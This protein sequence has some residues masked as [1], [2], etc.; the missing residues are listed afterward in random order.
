MSAAQ[1][2]LAGLKGQKGGD[3][4]RRQ[5]G[6]IGL[7]GGGEPQ[8]KPAGAQGKGEL[9]DN[10]VRLHVGGRRVLNQVK[11]GEKHPPFGGSDLGG[12]PRPRSDAGEMG[13]ANLQ[14]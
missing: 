14:G 7:E 13:Q 5:E 2:G 8:A 10:G 3:A 9:G 1:W 12:E 4:G 11:G 6:G